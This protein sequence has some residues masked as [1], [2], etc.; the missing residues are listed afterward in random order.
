MADASPRHAV[1]VRAALAYAVFSN[2]IVGVWATIAPRGFYD[3]FPGL[4]KVWVAVDGPYNEHLVRDVGS[5]ALALT[6]VCVAAFL[7]L[8]RPLVITAGLAVFVQAIP[9]VAHH[10]RHTDPFDT[11][12]AVGIIGGI[13]LTG[14]A[15]LLVALLAYRWDRADFY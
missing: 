10:L 13:A 4:G 15:G 2:A 5:W 8:S 9:H 7:T 14:L 3:E 1:I 11:S 6:I 12:D